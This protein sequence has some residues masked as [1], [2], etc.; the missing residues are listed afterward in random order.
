MSKMLIK[1]RCVYVDI[2]AEL[3]FIKL[4]FL[5]MTSFILLRFN[6]CRDL[7][8]GPVSK[9]QDIDI[10]N[11]KPPNPLTVTHINQTHDLMVKKFMLQ[12]FC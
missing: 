9:W 4:S 2:F 6:F 12:V 7:D 10:V 1:I 3:I 11:S 8:T 5:L